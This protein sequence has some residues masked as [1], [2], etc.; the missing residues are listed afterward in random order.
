MATGDLQGRGFV[1]PEVAGVR[2]GFYAISE[3]KND[4][5]SHE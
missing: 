4:G 3:W 5:V 2:I 1:P